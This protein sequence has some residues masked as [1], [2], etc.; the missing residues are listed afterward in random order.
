MIKLLGEIVT[1]M[2]RSDLHQKWAIGDVLRLMGPPLLHRQFVELREGGKLVGFGTFGFLTKEAGQGFSDRTRKLQ[3]DDW[4]AGD[5]I[6]IVD[7]LAPLGHGTEL[8]QL[9]RDTLI[10][11]GFKGRRVTFVRVKGDERRISEVVL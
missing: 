5:N 2:G 10:E 3:P 8:A 1:L 7:S 6:W 4:K 9:L 11:K